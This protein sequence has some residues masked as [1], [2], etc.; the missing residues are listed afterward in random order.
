MHSNHLLLE[1][2]IHMAL[3]LEPSKAIFFPTMT[4]IVGTLDPKSRSL[5]VIASCLNARMYVARFD[6]LWGNREYHQETLENLKVAVKS[7]K[8]CAIM[9]DMVGP[10]LQV[11]NKTRNLIALIG[12]GLVVLTPDR[13]QEPS[14]K[15]LPINFDGLAKVV[16]T[17]DTGFVGQYLFT[18][19]ETTSVWLEVSEIKAEDVRHAQATYH[20]PVE[21]L[22]KKAV[23]YLIGKAL[24]GRR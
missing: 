22:T 10:E 13:G 19:S 11:A 20:S 17:G 7:K 21:T 23:R 24:K 18:G 4:K 8:L 12:D 2:P 1:E 9:L 3:I 5:E 15:L 14:S 6:F 16:E